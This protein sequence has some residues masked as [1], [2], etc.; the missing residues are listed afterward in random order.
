MCDAFKLISLIR[1]DC[2]FCGV[3]GGIMQN[4]QAPLCTFTHVLAPDNNEFNS[5]CG[6]FLIEL[7]INNLW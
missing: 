3:G 7:F 4:F 6:K 5:R 1:F 2:F